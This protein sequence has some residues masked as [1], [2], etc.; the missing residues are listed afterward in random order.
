V[1]E[2]ST[3]WGTVTPVALRM[4]PTGKRL[5]GKDGTARWKRRR[6]ATRDEV[7]E[8]VARACEKAGFPAPV[9]VLAGPDPVM[10]GSEPARNYLSRRRQD[11]P[12]RRLVHAVVRFDKPVKGPVAVGFYRHF[13]LGL[14][15][16]LLFDVRWTVYGRHTGSD[17]PR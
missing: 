2:A 13:G 12:P 1:D 16:P 17:L 5:V 10:T 9:E 3:L 7:N 14:M 11:D 15:A 8:E 6:P 4:R